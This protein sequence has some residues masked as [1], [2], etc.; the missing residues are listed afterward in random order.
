MLR[1]TLLLFI[2]LIVT[3]GCKKN[4]VSEAHPWVDK[5]PLYS[6]DISIEGDPYIYSYIS[7]STSAHGGPNTPMVQLGNDSEFRMSQY[8]I[9]KKVY[10]EVKPYIV[11]LRD[12]TD[13]I[14]DTLHITY[15]TKRIENSKDWSVV[16]QETIT[17]TMSTTKDPAVILPLMFSVTDDSTITVLPHDKYITDSVTLKLIKYDGSILTFSSGIKENDM[18]LS[19]HFKEDKA[20]EEIKANLSFTYQRTEAT[21]VVDVSGS[22]VLALSN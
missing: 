3:I 13:T 7:F 8:Y 21:K 15:G 19:I 17:Q 5:S 9:Y 10:T 16:Y 20:K 14:I 22:A 1:Y 11:S 4:K 6:L 2:L 12:Y 18:S